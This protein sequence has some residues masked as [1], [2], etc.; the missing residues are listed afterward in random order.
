MKASLR[1][2]VAAATVAAGLGLGVGSAIAAQ[3]QVGPFPQD[4]CASGVS[5]A[6]PG[7]APGIEQAPRSRYVY[8]VPDDDLSG[9]GS[10]G[11]GGGG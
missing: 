6:H 8:N 4:P 3:A 7:P 11:G 1:F 9:R 2:S 10:D 5:C